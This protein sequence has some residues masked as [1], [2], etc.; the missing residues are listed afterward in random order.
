[1][2]IQSAHRAAS[3]GA[4]AFL[5]VHIVTEILAQRVHVLDAVIPFLSPFRTFYIGL[6]TIASDLII[7]LAITGIM[8]GRFNASGK[9]WRWR[10][11]HYA[12]YLSFVFGVWHGLLGR[13]PRQAVRGLE[14]RLRGRVRRCSAWRCGCSATR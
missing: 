6:G 1:M 7:L 3:F 8:R 4:V 5:I 13:P 10:A 14:L 9:A 11:I 12:S 2:F